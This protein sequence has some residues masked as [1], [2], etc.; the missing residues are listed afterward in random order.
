MKKQIVKAM[1][2]KFEDVIYITLNDEVDKE[3]LK[4]S[5]GS[6]STKSSSS[7][8]STIGRQARAFISKSYPTDNVVLKIQDFDGPIE[9]LYELLV[10]D[11]HTQ[12]NLAVCLNEFVKRKI[13]DD[14]YSVGICKLRS[15]VKLV[16]SLPRFKLF[17]LLLAHLEHQDLTSQI[18]FRILV[19]RF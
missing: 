2:T 1:Q 5:S 8:S 11:G 3:S 10:R 14:Y 9:L 16:E 12:Q 4:S 15:S 17:R 18:F 19:S 13:V 7:N 6:S